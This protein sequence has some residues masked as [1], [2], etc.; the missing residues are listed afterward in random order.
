MQIVLD[1]RMRNHSGIGTYIRNLS[2]YI[3]TESAN[4]TAPIFSI[5]EQLEFPFK[6]PVCDLFWSPQYNVPIL[7]VRAKQRVVTIHDVY[8]LAFFDELPVTHK[9]YVKYMIEKACKVSDKIVTVSEFSKQ[10]I[11]KYTAIN[12]DKITV[13]YNGADEGFNSGYNFNKIDEPYILFVGNVKKNKNLKNA[14]LAFEA[15][16]DKM[17]AKFYIVGKKEGFVSGDAEVFEIIKRLDDKIFLTGEVSLE[18]LKNYYANA[19]LF[20]FPSYYEG[21]GLPILEAM[22]FG[23]P[24]IASNAASIPEVG[25][26][27]VTYFDPFDIE[28]IAVAMLE[29]ID[30]G[31]KEYTET[32]SRFSWRKCA[33]EHMKLFESLS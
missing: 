7:P 25:G 9:I 24:I 21:F 23:L 22:S 15:I 14:L 28:S 26:A 27:A 11:L 31:K 17:D 13:I 33:D 20:I 8:Q 10:E 32:L 29:N 18:E 2:H 6:I 1:D 12:P 4:M 5:K 19:K 16:A 30:C 3:D